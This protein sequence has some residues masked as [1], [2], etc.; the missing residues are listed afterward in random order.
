MTIYIIAGLLIVGLVVFLLL[1]KPN[2]QTSSG[3]YFFSTQSESNER[4]QNLGLDKTS[5]D[6]SYILD[7]TKLSFP[8]TQVDAAKTGY[9][10]EPEKDWVIDLIS[11]NGES[12]KKDDIS[13]LF[14]YDW[15]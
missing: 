7:S 11:V 3:N 4:I 12:F 2:K 9:K 14:D 5:E 13:R 10:A 8:I 15:R 6:A 1:W